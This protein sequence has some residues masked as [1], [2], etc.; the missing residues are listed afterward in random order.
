MSIKFC[1]VCV[2]TKLPFISS[3]NRQSDLDLNGKTLLV[4]VSF[5]NDA[6]T[7]G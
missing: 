2:I 6:T 7:D 1:L 5:I 3:L 4:V